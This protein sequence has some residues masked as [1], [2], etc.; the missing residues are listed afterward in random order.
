VTGKKVNDF[1]TVAFTATLGLAGLAACGYQFQVEGPG[2]TIGSGPSAIE[3]SNRPRIAIPLFENNS[4]E[5]NLEVKYTAYTR[6]EFAAGSGAQVVTASEEADLI[7][8]GLIITVIL[9]TLTFDIN[10]TLETRTTVYVNVSVQERQTGKMVWNQTV[11]ASSEFFVTDDL[12]FNRVLQTRALEQAGR[13][14][15]EDLA[16]RFLDHVESGSLAKAA[17]S[18]EGVAPAG[19]IIPGLPVP[20]SKGTR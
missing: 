18:K 9:P 13:L 4:F 7:L 10:R 2:P 8:K 20:G 12:Q 15:A 3:T 1:L 19:G 11:T 5:P 17:A 14:I 6:H 16:A